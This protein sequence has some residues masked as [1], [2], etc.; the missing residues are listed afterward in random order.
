MDTLLMFDG[1]PFIL[2]A[3]FSPQACFKDHA[4]TLP[5]VAE[6]VKSYM[7]EVLSE[8]SVAYSL[9]QSMLDEQDKRDELHPIYVLHQNEDF[10]GLE[11][12]ITVK[13]KNIA[14]YVEKSLRNKPLILGSAF[15]VNDFSLST[16]PPE[17]LFQVMADDPVPER[18][19]NEENDV[20]VR[21]AFGEVNGE[22]YMKIDG[23]NVGR[24]ARAV[25]VQLDQHK[26]FTN[27]MRNAAGRVNVRHLYQ[28]SE[29]VVDLLYVRCKRRVT[30]P[31]LESR[32]EIVYRVGNVRKIHEIRQSQLNGPVSSLDTI[33]AER[34][35]LL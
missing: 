34:R 30:R 4:H 35:G 29:K 18:E 22:Y 33:V 24:T 11:D 8:V 10:E 14:A 7:F 1:C 20:Y 31:G 19:I 26:V 6:L 12:F 28:L 13:S 17:K 23:V 15:I 21:S 5:E 9:I 25:E 2:E 3:A 27:E 32:H 16:E